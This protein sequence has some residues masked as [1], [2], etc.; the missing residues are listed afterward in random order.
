VKKKIEKETLKLA[1]E[2]AIPLLREAGYTITG[3]G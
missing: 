1:L 3:R 2:D